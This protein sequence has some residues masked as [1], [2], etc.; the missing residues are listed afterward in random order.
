MGRVL[1]EFGLFADAIPPPM[2]GLSRHQYW[3]A[4]PRLWTGLSHFHQPWRVPLPTSFP[5]LEACSQRRYAE[6]HRF[7]V[8]FRLG[9]LQVGPSHRE[10]GL[11]KFSTE[12]RTAKTAVL[13]TSRSFFQHFPAR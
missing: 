8:L 2:H 7:P 4:P 6:L 13:V 10:P 1:Q 11:E 12:S 9:P 3:T 5:S